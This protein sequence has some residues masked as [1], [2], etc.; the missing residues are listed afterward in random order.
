MKNAFDTAVGGANVLKGIA[1]QYNLNLSDYPDLNKLSN[2]IKA[3]GGSAGEVGEF[4]TALQSLK[5]E[6]SQVV[7]R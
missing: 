1:S 3:H 2:A 4:Q 7:S 5:T 6:Y